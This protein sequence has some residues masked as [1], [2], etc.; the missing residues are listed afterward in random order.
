[1]VHNLIRGNEDL[2]QKVED[3]G[4]F[5]ENQINKIEGLRIKSKAV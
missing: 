3:L 1:M 4:K 5:A 2:I